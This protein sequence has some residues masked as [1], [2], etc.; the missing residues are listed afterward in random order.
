[1][2]AAPCERF[3]GGR[4]LK[5]ALERDSTP[6][7]CSE[8]LQLWQTDAEFRS[9]FLDVLA[10]APFSEFRWE[11]PPITAG[12][13]SRPFEFVL[14]DSP[15]LA[16]QPDP[17]AFVEHFRSTE[18]DVLSFPNLGRDAV[19]V[20]PCPREPHSAY[21]HIA[22]FAREAP[23]LQRHALWQ[24]VGKVMEERL[25]PNRIWLSTAGAGVP[26]LHIRLDSRPKYYGHAPYRDKK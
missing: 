16:Q 26:W 4:V 14:L 13:V 19:L 15:G 6:I 17:E 2:W 11:T 10:N 5:F 8:T 7:A 9:F 20:V 23:E 22:A 1:M 21:G 18:A 24:L 12:T 25:G 3:A